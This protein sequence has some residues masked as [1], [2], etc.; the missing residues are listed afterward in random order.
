M[1][2]APKIVLH[3]HAGFR[4]ELTALIGQF[5]AQGVKFV[6]VVGQD[7]AFL[8]DAIDELCVGDGTTSYFMLTSSHEGES[9]EE[10]MEFAQML[11]GEYAGEVQLVEF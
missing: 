10:A 9:V 5:I 7:C 6:G 3:S 4:P 8:E 1:H 11:S 2:Y